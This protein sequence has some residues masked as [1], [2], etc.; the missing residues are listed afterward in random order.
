MVAR[1]LVYVVLYGILIQ[2]FILL[3]LE[4][5]HYITH[6]Y[7]YQRFGDRLGKVILL[8]LASAVHILVALFFWEA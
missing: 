1:I 7:E 5:G 3:I 6:R 2:P 4:W 8:I